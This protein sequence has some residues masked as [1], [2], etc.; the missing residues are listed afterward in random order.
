MIPV[1]SA[2]SP[3]VNESQSDSFAHQRS[4]I[5]GDVPLECPTP[6]ASRPRERMVAN[7]VDSSADRCR[8]YHAGR[9][10]VVRPSKPANTVVVS[11]F[12][13]SS[14]TPQV[15]RSHPHH[16]VADKVGNADGRHC[17]DTPEWTS[18]AVFHSPQIRE[19]TPHG[20]GSHRE[21]ILAASKQGSDG[22]FRNGRAASIQPIHNREQ[23]HLSPSANDSI[24][25][26]PLVGVSLVH[27]SIGAVLAWTARN[28]PS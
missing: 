28:V 1:M 21:P 2:V 8:A 20:Q 7:V 3:G 14:H 23:P 19:R 22:L 12:V 26:A 4:P 9:R 16:I 27:I 6:T 25:I 15:L 18:Q 13:I 24:P 11:G 10:A 17:L 5:S